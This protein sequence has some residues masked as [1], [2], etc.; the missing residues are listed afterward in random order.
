MSLNKKNWHR[1]S[2]YF[3]TESIDN[4]WYYVSIDKCDGEI[5]YIQ[6]RADR[7][8]HIKNFVQIIATDVK[9]FTHAMDMIEKHKKAITSNVVFFNVSR[10]VKSFHKVEG[11]GPE[12]T[13]FNET[14]SKDELNL[15]K[16]IEV[17]ND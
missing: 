11:H 10:G 9:N 6:F 17:K 7:Y 3:S 5:Y 4:G 1:S 12:D 16:T 15:I 8:L 14:L 2:A 13:K